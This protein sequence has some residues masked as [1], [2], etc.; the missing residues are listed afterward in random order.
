MKIFKNILLITGITI[1]ILG[2]ILAF[3]GKYTE[4]KNYVIK[5]K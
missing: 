2:Y 4:N 3:K 1:F 5:N